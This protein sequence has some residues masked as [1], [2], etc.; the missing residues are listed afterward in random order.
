MRVVLNPTYSHRSDSRGFSG[1]KSEL[2]QNST[3]N[4]SPKKP[5]GVLNTYSVMARE[6]ITDTV[7]MIASMKCVSC[8]D[9]APFTV[10]E[11]SERLEELPG[12]SLHSGSIQKEFHFKSYL[13]GLEFAYSLGRIAELENHH[14]DLSIGWRRVKV[15]WSTHAIKG[16]SQNDFIMASKTELEYLKQKKQEIR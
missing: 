11:A 2:T 1:K 14:P 13:D 12:W 3:K 10:G 9:A 16:L 6:R 8:K 4:E 5:F 7:R 15:E